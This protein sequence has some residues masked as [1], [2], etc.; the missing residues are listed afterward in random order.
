M[1][2]GPPETDRPTDRRR[3]PEASDGPTR[4]VTLN[5]LVQEHRRRLERLNLAELLEL[6][7]GEERFRVAA[8]VSAAVLRD[9]RAWL[10]TVS[11]ATR[12]E[13]QERRT[14]LARIDATLAIDRRLT[15]GTEAGPLAEMANGAEDGEGPR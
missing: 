4:G 6:A 15:R 14:W 3:G 11:L 7:A 13:E 2:E 9:V 1:T 10:A 12:A 8:G 5:R